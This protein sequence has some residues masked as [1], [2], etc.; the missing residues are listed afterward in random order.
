MKYKLAIFDL[1]GTVLDTLADLAA[2]VNAALEK[3][4]YPRHSLEEVRS[5][6]GNGVANLIRRAVPAETDENEC[7]AILADFKAYYREH[8]NDRTKPYDGIPELLS[9]LKKAGIKV[10]INSNKYDAALQS[11]CRIHFDSLYDY[12]VGESEITPRKPDPAA[13]RRI[14]EAVGVS[15]AETIYIGDSSVDI[16]TAANAGVDSAWVSWG[17]RRRSEMEGCVLSHAFD[18]VAELQAF[19]L[20]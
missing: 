11:L 16:A 14:M 15:P 2:A 7:V 10:G 6:V 13:A 19:L 9:A 1:D 18:T 20:N 5:M 8:V 12:A 17:F 4:A 3:H